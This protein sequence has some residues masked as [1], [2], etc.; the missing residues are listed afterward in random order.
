MLDFTLTEEQLAIQK[1]A[2]DFAKR[3]IKPVALQF[4]Q[5]KEGKLAEQ[6]FEKAAV[7]LHRRQ[8][9]HQRAHHRGAGLRGTPM[10]LPRGGAKP[11]LL[12]VR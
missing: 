10:S 2:R 4:E 5:D 11:V 9:V 1:L 3:E 7:D 6:I 8:R 12:V